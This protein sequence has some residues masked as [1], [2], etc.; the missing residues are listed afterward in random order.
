MGKSEGYLPIASSDEGILLRPSE[1]RKSSLQKVLNGSVIALSI[2]GA[3]SL[4]YS[5]GSRNA[6][7]VKSGTLGSLDII[8]RPIFISNM[9]TVPTGDLHYYMQFDKTF[10]DGS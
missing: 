1:K 4:G 5:L 6:H 10:C 8:F 3:I 9:V 2:L 7:V